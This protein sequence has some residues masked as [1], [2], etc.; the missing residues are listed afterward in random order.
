ME[1]P[2]FTQADRRASPHCETAEVQPNGAYDDDPPPVS[3]AYFTL[4]HIGEQTPHVYLGVVMATGAS[5]YNAVD[6][7]ERRALQ[8]ARSE[9]VRTSMAR[10][11]ALGR[12]TYAVIGMRITAGMSA[13]GQ[14]EWLAY[15]TLL[16]LR[17]DA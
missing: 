4:D 5:G 17:Q 11:A 8:T 16:Q 10:R 3:V 6:A 12:H 9:H 7:L 14:P 2:H 13:S 15:G 1:R